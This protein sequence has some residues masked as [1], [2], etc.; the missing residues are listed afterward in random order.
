[1]FSSEKWSALK[2]GTSHEKRRARLSYDTA[3]WFREIGLQLDR[4]LGVLNFASTVLAI[5][6][7]TA[8]LTGSW[9]ALPSGLLLV[10]SIY[11][12]V[13]AY[14]YPKRLRRQYAEGKMPA[15]KIPATAESLGH[16][17]NR[18]RFEDHSGL[19]VVVPDHPQ[20]FDAVVLLEDPAVKRLQSAVVGRYLKG[21]LRHYEVEDAFTDQA[22]E[23]N[24]SI[25]VE[26]AAGADTQSILI[27]E[28]IGTKKP[29]GGYRE[30]TWMNLPLWQLSDDELKQVVKAA[31]I[32][33]GLKDRAM[34]KKRIELAVTAIAK[35]VR[36]IHELEQKL[37]AHPDGATRKKLTNLRHKSLLRKRV[38]LHFTRFYDAANREESLSD[39]ELAQLNNLS[40]TV[41]GNK[42]DWINNLSCG[43]YRGVSDE[44]EQTALGLGFLGNELIKKSRNS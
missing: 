44:L 31:P 32:Y 43:C 4:K 17:V 12:L 15:G 9:L 26:G 7:I 41:G 33:S 36:E 24:F 37:A 19:T 3:T 5:I 29:R 13:Y 23:S 22:E 20:G 28:E 38:V 8:S 18:I 34:R 11:W 14:G 35:L 40:P 10:G 21:P 2:I 6:F 16:S 30:A 27:P 1:M 39:E 42:N 25:H